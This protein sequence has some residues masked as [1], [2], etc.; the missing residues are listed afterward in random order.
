[1]LTSRK[2]L[3]FEEFKKHFK[4]MD[5]TVKEYDLLLFLDTKSNGGE[6]SRPTFKELIEQHNKSN[7]KLTPYSFFDTYYLAYELTETK[8]NQNK[9]LDS[10]LISQKN[11]LQNHS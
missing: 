2:Q 6:F 8:R 7:S 9:R 5:K 4:S 3:L 11:N 10:D 1:M